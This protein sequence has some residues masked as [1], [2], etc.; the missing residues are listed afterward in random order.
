MSRET[1]QILDGV[2]FASIT[3]QAVINNL[4]YDAEL[5]MVVQPVG[6]LCGDRLVRVL[7]FHATQDEDCMAFTPAVKLE[8]REPQHRNLNSNAKGTGAMLGSSAQSVLRPSYKG[9]QRTV[10]VWMTPPLS[11]ADILRKRSRNPESLIQAG[12]GIGRHALRSWVERRVVGDERVVERINN[13]FGD[14]ALITMNPAPTWLIMQRLERKR[15]LAKSE[16][17]PTWALYRGEF[18]LE[19]VGNYRPE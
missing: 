11:D 4:E 5:G 13:G 9:E 16:T 12:I 15:P 3:P 10:G 14:H 17:P 19:R 6:S 1:Q 2:E 18:P 7:G 8:D